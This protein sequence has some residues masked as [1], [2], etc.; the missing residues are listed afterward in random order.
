MFGAGIQPVDPGAGLSGSTLCR[1][2]AV[3]G[4]HFR[5][6]LVWLHFCSAGYFILGAG[7]ALRQCFHFSL[8][9]GVFDGFLAI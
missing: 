3:S 4:V 6:F 2:M 1:H 7:A 9:A 5:A 8:H